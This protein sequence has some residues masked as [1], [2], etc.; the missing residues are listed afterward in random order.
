MGSCVFCS[1]YFSGTVIVFSRGCK[2]LWTAII[3]D[4]SINLICGGYVWYGWR[5]IQG[6]RRDTAIT[7][8]IIFWW[9]HRTWWCNKCCVGVWLVPVALAMF[10]DTSDPLA[11]N[12][13][14]QYCGQNEK[15]YFRIFTSVINSYFNAYWKLF[16][17]DPSYL[18]PFEFF[19]KDLWAILI[20]INGNMFFGKNT[21]NQ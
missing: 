3:F 5:P 17:S 10:V 1:L 13:F 6:N 8:G 9:I 20:Y 21:K 12:S 7:S 14:W 18:I 11:H 19:L 16:L 15:L 2:R 4:I